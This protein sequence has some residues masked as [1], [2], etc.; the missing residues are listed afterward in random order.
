[1][2]AIRT[3]PLEDNASRRRSVLHRKPVKVSYTCDFFSESEEECIDLDTD[4]D[5]ASHLESNESSPGVSAKYLSVR[6]P[7]NDASKTSA[8]E[9]IAINGILLRPTVAF[10]TF[11]R[12][13]AERKAIDD[14]R[15]AGEPAP[16]T[17]DVILQKYFFCN[18]YRVLDKLCQ[19]IIKEVIE[20]GPQD[21][22]EVV[23]R[24]VLFNL[25][26][27]IE[28]WELL[29]EKLGPLTW[30]GY[31]RSS[32]L[33]VLSA[34]FNRGMALY[35]RAFIKPA[36][37]FGH[38]ENYRNHLCLLEVL[39]ENEFPNKL[40]DAPYMADVFEYLISFPSMG[41]FSAYQLMLSLS[42]T[43]VLN[44]HCNDFVIAGPG[45]IS[46]LKKLFGGSMVSG[47][48]SNP[49][50]AIEVMRYLVKTQDQHFKRLGLAF[51][52]LG[53]KKL[54]MDV[55]DIEHTLCEVDKY[56]RAAHPELKGKRTHI[57]RSFGPSTRRH[58]AEPILPKAWS[59][60]SRR[61]PRLRPDKTLVI[62]KR[63]TIEAIKD[64]KGGPDGTLYLVYWFGYSAKDATWEPEEL[65][66][67]DAP[68]ALSEY[69]AK[70]A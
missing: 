23:F 41:E 14:R 6:G 7:T 68:V 59:H 31:H 13:A 46:G 66:L 64:H 70:I 11:W 9:P 67:S 30:G 65:L 19:Y 4:S 16:W 34:A 8:L 62:D 29:V 44:F 58:L 49:G 37:R 53:P 1:M 40:L 60:P 12:F 43:D 36:P 38:A 55:S 27:K 32:Y 47:S 25:F 3:K 35:T 18:T 28:T 54:P 20:K 26:T 21:P 56:C 39:M 22:V 15:R 52:G 50:F 33:K 2:P 24:V 5:V 17:E 10:D 42:Y 57:T 45:S 69:K 51:S 61:T 63:Y 48:H